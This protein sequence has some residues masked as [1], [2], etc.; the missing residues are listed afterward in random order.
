MIRDV[1]SVGPNVVGER[2]SRR[3]D[4]GIRRMSTKPYAIVTASD[5]HCGDFVCTYWF[6]SIADNVDLNKINVV[7]LDYGLSEAQRRLLDQRGVRGTS[8]RV[9]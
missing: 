9:L 2:L 4:I 3:L 7:V 6:P 1:V 5:E 8:W